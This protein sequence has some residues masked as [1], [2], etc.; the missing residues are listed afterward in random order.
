MRELPDM[1][2]Y[3]NAA[4]AVVI[5]AT[6]LMVVWSWRSMRIAEKRREEAK[7]KGR[8]ER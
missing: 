8:E 4:Y 3:V 5:V 2:A 1:M 7:R 6:V